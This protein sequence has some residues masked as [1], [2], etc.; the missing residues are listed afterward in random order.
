MNGTSIKLL[1]DEHVWKG[2]TKALQER[3]Y[4]AVSIV[5][6]SQSADDE[7]LLEIAAAQGRTVLTYDADDFPGIASL[8]YEAGRE[9]AGI[10]LSQEIPPGELLRRTLRLLQ[11]VSAEEIR[12]ITR[13]LED[14][15]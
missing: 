12:N 4:D 14:F 6:L 5:D 3:G 15:K 9:H 2:L 8:W 10:V 11:T 13:R 1:L 7:P